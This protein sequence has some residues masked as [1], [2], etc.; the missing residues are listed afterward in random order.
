MACTVR[1]AC[2]LGRRQRT[3]TDIS[4]IHIF[5]TYAHARSNYTCR[6]V[7]CFQYSFPYTISSFIRSPA[8]HTMATIVEALAVFEAKCSLQA[9]MVKAVVIEE[10]HNHLEILKS[11]S[12]TWKDF[13]KLPNSNYAANFAKPTLYEQLQR[14]LETPCTCKNLVLF[15]IPGSEILNEHSKIRLSIPENSSLVPCNSP[16]AGCTSPA[17]PIPCVEGYG[18]TTKKRRNTSDI[19]C[20]NK[21]PRVDMELATG[22]F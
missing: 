16:I 1:S 11:R 2:H 5:G 12:M 14:H 6:V 20:L 8:L 10:H 7:F 4:C 3:C 13:A 19:E 18:E 15:R 17:T 21:R 22:G 9:I